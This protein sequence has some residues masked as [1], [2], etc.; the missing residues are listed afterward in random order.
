SKRSAAFCHSLAHA[1]ANG[2][3]TVLSLAFYWRRLCPHRGLW[4]FCSSLRNVDYSPLA[5]CGAHAIRSR[6]N[7]VGKEAGGRCFCGD[8][9]V[10]DG[11][12][13]HHRGFADFGSFTPGGL[14]I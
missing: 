10:D 9:A 12:F 7:A 5:R 1:R 3:T 4:A 14:I 11:Y 2:L 8:G 6:T 13:G